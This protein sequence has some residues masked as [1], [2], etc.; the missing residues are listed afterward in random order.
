MTSTLAR[1][2]ASAVETVNRAGRILKVVQRSGSLGIIDKAIGDFQTEADRNAQ[3]CIVESLS[4]K[5]PKMKIIAEEGHLEGLP[6]REDWIVEA[7]SKD[8]L[9]ETMPSS[10]ADVQEEDIVC[11]VDPLDGTRDYAQGA[12]D[13]VTVLVGFAVRGRAVAGVIHQ[14]FYGY[15]AEKDFIRSGRTAWGIVGVGV[16]GLRP[17]IPNSGFIVATSR[18]RSQPAIDACIKSMRPTKV[19]RVAGAGYKML[20]VLE[21]VAHTYLFPSAGLK[22]WDIC[23][24]EALL[25]AAGGAVADIHGNAIQ[26]HAQADYPIWCGVLA[27]RRKNDLQ[28]YLKMIPKDVRKRMLINQENTMDEL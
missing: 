25:V 15:N 28:G 16:R 11:W 14:P 19:I 8:V 6:L 17:R 10:L 22:K 27:A 2:V 24:P 3:V 9:K 21:G 20:L 26:Y 18:V 5:F 7:M 4:M 1:A 23:A 13:H 12:I